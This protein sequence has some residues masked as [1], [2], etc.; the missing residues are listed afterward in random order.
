MRSTPQDLFAELDRLGLAHATI[1][2]PPVFTVEEAKLLRGKI[3]GGHT[4]NLFL[5]DK[6]DQLFLGVTLEDVAVDLKELGPLIGARGRLSFA[7]ADL[8]REH[9]GV[10]PGSVTP[11]AL[12]NNRSRTVTPVLDETMLAANLLNFHPLENTATTAISSDDLLKF[13]AAQG[14]RALTLRFPR[15]APGAISEADQ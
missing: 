3:E 10:E 8:L 1:T 5:K 14:H 9:L 7:S 15:R 2:H 4:K 11:F 13:V 6:K 12:F